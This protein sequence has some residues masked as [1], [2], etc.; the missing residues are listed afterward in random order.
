[1]DGSG[2]YDK[3]Y[4]LGTKSPNALQFKW[5][6]IMYAPVY[7]GGC[8]FWANGTTSTISI[9]AKQLVPTQTYT[10]LL[11]VQN[12]IGAQDN[13]TVR[14]T[15][16]PPNVNVPKV[17]LPAHPDK[18]NSMDKVVL[19]AYISTGGDRRVAGV[20]YSWSAMQGSTSI[21]LAS[22][23]LTPVAS[24]I[25]VSATP[26]LVQFALEKNALQAGQMYQFTLTASFTDELNS[27]RNSQYPQ[28]VQARAVLSVVMNAPPVKELT[29]A[30]RIVA[31]LEDLEPETDAEEL[32]CEVEEYE[33]ED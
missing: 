24:S 21:D 27:G 20:S 31:M 4:P 18:Y 9:P 11:L 22:T 17:Y 3:D 8:P 2:S 19:E 15:V 1:L 14:V 13:A 12:S 32:G 30:Q 33:E 5:N 26:S 23:A 25:S 16:V 6:C 10:F 7:G 28:W 29:V